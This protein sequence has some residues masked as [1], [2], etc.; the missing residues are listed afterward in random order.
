MSGRVDWAALAEPVTRRLLGEPNKRLTRGRRW[1]YGSKGSL[2]VD[3]EKRA[4]FDF[5]GKRGGHL[6]QLVEREIGGDW[7]AARRWLEQEGF[8]APWKPDG[9]RGAHGRASARHGRAAGRRESGPG[10]K[11]AERGG[12]V[13]SR[14]DSGDGED[15]AARVDLARSIWAAAGPVP[16]SPVMAYLARRAAWPAPAMF[17]AGW[18]AMRVAIRW[19]SRAAL[20]DVDRRFARFRLL[21]EFPGDAAGA[22]V[23]AYT[24]VGRPAA[25]G[26]RVRAVTMDALT[27]D[28]ART[29]GER[30]RRTRGV[31]N[32]AACVMK[33][34]VG[35]GQIAIVE[36]EVDALAV[37]L[38]AKGAVP[39]YG[40]V[41]EVRAVGGTSG[42]QPDRAADEGGRPVLLLPDGPGADG[43]GTAAGLAAACATRLR[44]EGRSVQERI[45]APGDEAGDPAADLAVLLMERAA[46]FERAEPGR[47]N[48]E[49]ERADRLAW[50]SILGLGTEGE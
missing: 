5:E 12:E 19:M 50:R 26:A 38:M 35:A 7:K 17:G 21:H 37:V 29:A 14:G 47:E 28:G 15:E 4:W 33:A 16:D 18:P 24:V 48:G 49:I 9:R 45:R 46:R 40:D 41:G 2:A 43:K 3:L 39:G 10:R 32:G 34:R 22:M 20:A 8:I 30:W 31:L 1:R 6:E 13:A 42:F 27:A 44:A 23:A 11:A 36:G 25:E